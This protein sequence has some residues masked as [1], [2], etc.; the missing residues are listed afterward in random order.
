[1]IIKKILEFDQRTSDKLRIDRSKKTLWLIAAFFA[2]SGDSWWW[3]LGLFILWILG[4]AFHIFT[5]NVIEFCAFMAAGILSLAILIFSVKLIVKRRRPKGEWGKI[6][7]NTDP[8]SFPSG[9]AARTILIAVIVFSIAPIW[10]GLLAL[11]WAFTVSIARVAM[12]V[13]Y[14]S[15]ILVGMIIGIFWG[16]IMLMLKPLLVPAFP[17]AFS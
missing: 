2:H 9:H 4:K 7:R 6:Y 14:V 13:H 5:S 17:F 10:I 3:L 12:R 1:M 15:D 16:I 11:L 8:H